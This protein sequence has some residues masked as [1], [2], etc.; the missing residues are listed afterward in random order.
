MDAPRR[1]GQRGIARDARGGRTGAARG[2]SACQEGEV[3][4]LQNLLQAMTTAFQGGNRTQLQVLEKVFSFM[5]CTDD[6]KVACTVFMLKG[7][8]GHWFKELFNQ[9]YFPEELRNEKESQFIQLTQGTKSFVE[10]ERNTNSKEK[11]HGPQKRWN[12]NFQGKHD[13][14][15]RGQKR[16]RDVDANKDHPV[17]DTYGKKHGGVCFRKIGACFK[18]G[19]SGESLC[20]KELLRSCTVQLEDK[21]LETDL[22]ILDMHDFDIIF[23]MDWLSAYHANVKCFGKEVVFN[24]PRNFGIEVINVDSDGFVGMMMVQ[25]TL[26]DRIKAVEQ[27]INDEDYGRCYFWKEIWFQC[28]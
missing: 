20:A 19:K 13:N 11:S 6:Q 5:N 9:K 7:D 23:G 25:P 1:V 28:F 15:N 22:I 3:A 16:Q 4:N 24:P 12:K 14:K 21:V 8:A 26:I 27:C 2:D 18:C 10:Y 17:C